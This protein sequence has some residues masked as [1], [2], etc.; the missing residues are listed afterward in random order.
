MGGL[1]SMWVYLCLWVTEVLWTVP[2]MCLSFW[3]V[4]YRLGMGALG[5]CN[6][7]R[8]IVDLFVG[9]CPCVTPVLQWIEGCGLL[10]DGQT[11]CAFNHSRIRRVRAATVWWPFM[12]VFT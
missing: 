7:L 4:L 8:A 11:C 5:R 1:V 9:L 2:L 6:G 3:E 12:V 10:A